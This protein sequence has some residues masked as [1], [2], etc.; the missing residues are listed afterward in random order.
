MLSAKHRAPTS[1]G[2]ALFWSGAMIA[3]LLQAWTY[4]FY[5]EPDGVNYLDIAAA[6]LRHDWPTA[7]N[8]YWSP[9]YSWLLAGTFFVFRP[10]PYMESTALH[11]LNFVIF[12][13]GLRCGEFFIAE[14]I[15]S[16]AEDGESLPPWALWWLGYSILL[17]VSLFMIS[18]WLDT[19]DLCVA[20][21]IYL[22]AGLLLR[23]R[24]GR[25]PEPSGRTFALCGLVLGAAYLAKTVMFV[26]AF[27][28]LLTAA[29]AAGRRG[30]RGTAIALTCFASISVPWI[31]VL[32]RSA[33]RLTYG[34]AGWVAYAV[35]VARSGSPIHP[36]RIISASPEVR[37]FSEPIHATYPPW[38]SPGYWSE[39]IRPRFALRAQLRASSRNAKEYL[40]MLSGQKEFLAAF[41]VLFVAWPAVGGRLAGQW[42]LLLPALSASGLYAL[43]HV[44]PRLV[45]GFFVLFWMALFSGLRGPDWSGRGRKA[46]LATYVVLAVVLVTAFKVVRHSSLHAPAHTEWQAAQSLRAMGLRSGD[47]VAY[48]GHT[49]LAD[50]W[51]HLAGLQIAADIQKEEMPAFWALS[52][53]ARGEIVARL[54]ALGI[55]AILTRDAPPFALREGW[56]F[57]SGTPY[58]VWPIGGT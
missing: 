28:F 32:S 25:S 44:E 11:L 53:S 41:F 46:R 47:R 10:S 13:V 55:R 22:A 42:P 26:V 15:A 36:R 57:I 34:D 16:A 5:I 24:S 30:I 48:F 21:L 43:V 27:A 51:A 1:R 19:P 49:T 35:F 2:R 31:V 23:V 38:Y 9:L 3:G 8:T 54:S 39:G 18:V 29:L 37:E 52:A 58:L 4:R 33:G 56:Q 14:L 45:G 12:L 50:Y 17:F 40:R 6:Y 20:A 7:I